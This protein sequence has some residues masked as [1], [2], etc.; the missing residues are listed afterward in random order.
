MEIQPIVSTSFFEVSVRDKASFFVFFEVWHL[1]FKLT[2]L[3]MMNAF[4]TRLFFGVP[5]E[6][7]PAV[8]SGTTFHVPV[9]TVAVP[10]Q[11]AATVPAQVTV[12]IPATNPIANLGPGQFTSQDGVHMDIPQPPPVGGIRR[13]D[14]SLEDEEDED[15]YEEDDDDADS[16]KRKNT[17]DKLE[18]V[19]PKRKER[20]TR[21]FP[22][23]VNGS[24][25]RKRA[26]TSRG[27]KDKLAKL[28]IVH[29]FLTTPVDE[30]RPRKWFAGYM[31]QDVNANTF[32]DTWRMMIA[33]KLITEVPGRQDD[34]P[35][36]YNINVRL[37]RRLR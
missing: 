1:Q 24:G 35:V 14:V 25:P 22:M 18:K 34:E 19:L 26:E 7:S 30:G 28:V 13:M 31:N 3:T 12:Q 4:F 20:M 37:R 17:A 6:T 15:D 8:A 9:R 29:L 11:V 36:M 5:A 2:K 23:K 32:I 21:K 16:I 10:A 33:R 27:T